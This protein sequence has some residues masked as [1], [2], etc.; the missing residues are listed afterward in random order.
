M[1][2]SREAYCI[3]G[4]GL[5]EP[6]AERRAPGTDAPQ[7]S[8]LRFGR[9]FDCAPALSEAEAESMKAKLKELGLLMNA[10]Q[11]E[12]S[13]AE[14]ESDIPSGYTYLGQ[15]IAHEI[16]FDSTGDTV[17]SGAEFKQLRT[18]QID[19][20][21]LYGGE[22]GPADR[23]EL[24]EEDDDRARLKV[25]MTKYVSSARR[26]FPNDLFRNAARPPAAASGTPPAA[27]ASAP[28]NPQTAVVGDPRN[29]ENLPLAQTHVAMV[30]FHNKVVDKLKA[31]GGYPTGKLFESARALVTRHFQWIV[32]HD[33]LPRLVDKDVLECVLDHGLRWFRPDDDGLYMPLEFS[34]AAFR[35]GHSMVRSSYE[36][37]ERHSTVR[38][39]DITSGGPVSIG[40]LF[41]LTGRG[42]NLGD[43]A[44]VALPSD[45]IIDWRRF[46]D[47]T[48]LGHVPPPPS[49]NRAFRLDTKLNFLLN[50]VKPAVG[51]SE[52][53]QQLA[54]M[55]TAISVRNL[56]RG[57]YL[58]LPT[59]EQVAE[60]MGETPLKPE[61]VA[62]GPHSDLLSDDDFRGKTPLWYYILKEAELAGG[63]RLGRVGSRIIAETL[64][65]LVESSPYS[66]RKETDWRP[67]F[68]RDVAAPEKK[69]F[70]MI[71]LLNFA[72]VVD[73]IGRFDAESGHHH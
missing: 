27:A 44:N 56:R 67:R 29:D 71:D 22:G 37:N 17:A 50:D 41:T 54:E 9:L 11:S 19:L 63:N 62:S 39:G 61:E 52:A 14:V 38:L 21:S 53:D 45:W 47:F 36:W 70:E 65:G 13:P 35:I 59:G 68:G 72:D 7:V 73:P 40:A 48:P 46:Y 18:P 5:M 16:T 33:Y 10:P 43:P 57:F 60:W 20:D 8:P 58:G 32:L 25:G 1:H 2:N 23:P 69:R 31:E 55:R 6:S 66:I 42:G 64:V 28:P 26:K 12:A 24:Y 34:A 4:E 3:R 30:R 15:F 51:T 49:L